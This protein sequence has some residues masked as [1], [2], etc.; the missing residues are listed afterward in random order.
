MT[1]LPLPFEVE[2]PEI[3]QI[4]VSSVCNFS[5]IMC[6]RNH[7]NR[8]DK[9]PFIDIDLIRKLIRE[10]SFKGSYFVELQMSGEPLLH[11]DLRAIVDL[12]KTTGVKVGLSTN[13]SLI[14]EKIDVLKDL[15]YITI[16][17]DSIS[18]YSNIRV[19][20]KLDVLLSN[21]DLLQRSTSAAVDLQIIELKGW[22]EEVSRL[23]DIFP[24]INIRTVPDCFITIDY[25]PSYPSV[26]KRICLNPWLSVSIHSNGNVVPCCFAFWDDIIYG[27]IKTRSLKDIWKGKEVEYIRRSHETQSYVSLCKRCYM[28]SPVLLHWNIFVNSLRNRI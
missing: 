12:I 10:D 13:G 22:E 28:R 24:S 2:L 6:P 11:P 4:E 7:Y 23:K 1:N 26:S 21:I 8:K 20:G 16:S 27:N 3:Y 14:H 17:V 25:P 19:N 9:T 15:D 5:C 18:D